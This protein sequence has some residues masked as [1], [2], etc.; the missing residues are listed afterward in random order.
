MT[1][2]PD[3]PAPRAPPV[4]L[5]SR[6]ELIA[7]MAM[8]AA[9]VAF[10]IDAMLPALPEMAAALS[11]QSPNQVQ[12]VVTFFVLGMGIGTL[13]TG[14][15]SDRFGRKP[16]VLVGSAIYILS[17]V[18]AAMADS[19]ALMLVARLC[20]GLGASGPRV[21]AMAIIRDLF[22][23]RQMAQVMSFVMMVFAIVP[24]MAPSL[25]AGLMVLA[26]WPA[27][28]WSFAVFAGFNA[29]WL[30]IRLPETLPT[31]ERRPFRWGSLLSAAREMWRNPVVRLSMLVQ[32]LVF[33]ML[34]AT[35]SSIQPIYEQVFDRAQSFPLWIGATSLLSASGSIVNAVLVMRLG[36]RRLVSLMLSV[37][38]GVSVLLLV[39]VMAGL[40]G[41]C[42]FALFLFWQFT[43]FFQATLTIG[44]LN[45]IA[46]QPMGHIAGMAASI[47]GFFA[48]VVAVF[49]AA[50]IGL[51]F[52]GT[53]VPLTL[54]IL[55]FGIVGLALMVAM[56]RAEASGRP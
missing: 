50:P 40:V 39:G 29:L 26:G 53:V 9:T 48:T 17:A 5:P 6:V 46:M 25:G 44:N 38:I 23:G 22:E 55:G 7:L 21:V 24:A 20:Q 42:L 13:F 35:I 12:L 18:L 8:L 54:G 37:Q 52:D 56:R 11:P 2:P 36:M 4:D 3:A 31:Q 34:F 16:V 30:M 27:I 41:D 28:F 51:A 15:L 47:I 33:G 49:L 14:G 32:S 19:L 43:A 1:P 10:S 45:A